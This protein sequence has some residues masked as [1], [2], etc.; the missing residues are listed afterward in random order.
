ME[1]RAIIVLLI[2]GL[3]TL[4]SCFSHQFVNIQKSWTEAQ[5]YCRENHTDLATIDDPE[6]MKALMEA[7]DSDFNGDAW[8]G[9]YDD[10]DSW[11]WSLVDSGFYSE[12]ETEFR[13]WK[14]S[15]PDNQDSREHC[16]NMINNGKWNDCPCD[17]PLYFICYD[18]DAAQRYI[19]ILESKTWREAQSYCREQHTDLASVRNQT[20]N[21]EIWNLA[22]QNVWIG[23]FRESWKWSDQSNSSYR[24]WSSV[25]PDNTGGN[26]NCAVVRISDSGRWRDRECND[27]YP[28]FCYDDNLVLVHENKSWDEALS[29]CRQHYRDLVSAPTKQV[30]RWVSRR[31]QNASTPHV[32]LGLNYSCKLHFWFWLDGTIIGTEKEARECGGK[33]AIQSGEEQSWVVLHETEKLNF[34]C[35]KCEGY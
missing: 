34:I 31:A 12:G 6:E 30:Q 25:Q 20:E 27:M 21:Q 4:C 15:Q 28:F 16:V 14:R 3:C 18:G 9:L 35:S 11:Q 24:G 8:I 5:S 26:Q 7:V 32:W 19:L 17:K 10:R 13:N 33:V 22:N 1:Q 23:L 2:S 29:F